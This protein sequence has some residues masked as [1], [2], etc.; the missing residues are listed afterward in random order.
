MLHAWP[1][2]TKVQINACS[3][4]LRHAS[5]LYFCKIVSFFFKLFFLKSLEV[6]LHIA[7]IMCFSFY[8]PFI[9]LV[10][11]F[12]WTCLWCHK[13]PWYLSQLSNNTC[14]QPGLLLKITSRS[15]KAQHQG[16]FFSTGWGLNRLHLIIESRMMAGRLE[17]GRMWNQ[18]KLQENV[19]LLKVFLKYVSLGHSPFHFGNCC[20]GVPYHC[21][22]C[23][24]LCIY[25]GRYDIHVKKSWS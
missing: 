9:F 20:T 17:I 11:E 25:D 10:C 15:L 13:G 16:S 14:S 23:S 7:L 6:S 22:Q 5:P 24:A 18:V 19:R 12:L 21:D 8:F 2:W 4:C 3:T 1:W